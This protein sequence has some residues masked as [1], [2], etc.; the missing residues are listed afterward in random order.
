MVIKK[1]ERYRRIKM[2][3]IAHSQQIKHKI[4]TSLIYYFLGK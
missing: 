2:L 1:K 4:I 3:I